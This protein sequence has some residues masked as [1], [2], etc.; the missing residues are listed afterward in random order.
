MLAQSVTDDRPLAG[1][2]VDGALGNA[3]LERELAEP[4]R[5]ERCQLRRLE[6]DRVAAGERR[7][8]LPRGDVEREVPGHD[9]ADYA[10][11]LAERQVDAARAGDRVAA[12]PVHRP[13]VGM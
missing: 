11:R 8:D 2:E 4:E 7:P 3:R 10:E 9:Q 6:D 12:A 1:E 5:G 13:G